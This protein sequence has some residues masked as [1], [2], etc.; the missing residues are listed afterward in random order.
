[1]LRRVVLEQNTTYRLSFDRKDNEDADRAV[2]KGELRFFADIQ[3]ESH[4]IAL[5]ILIVA[6]SS[7][8][9][10]TND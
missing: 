9:Q 7:D 10:N 4:S 5:P 8:I 1:L 2:F 3:E 6:E